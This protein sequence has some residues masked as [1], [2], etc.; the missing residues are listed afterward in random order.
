VFPATQSSIRTL[1]G[2]YAGAAGGHPAIS[3]FSEL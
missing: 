2:D 1:A 3:V